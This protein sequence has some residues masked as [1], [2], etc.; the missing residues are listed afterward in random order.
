MLSKF[1]LSYLFVNIFSRPYDFSDNV[2]RMH[3]E[4][5]QETESKKSNATKSIVETRLSFSMHTWQFFCCLF[6]FFRFH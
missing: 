4:V 1:L 6:F 2:R 3:S 5:I